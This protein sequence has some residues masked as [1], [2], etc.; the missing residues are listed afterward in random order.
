MDLGIRGRRAVVFGAG[1]GL[2]RAC[3]YANNA[4]GPPAGEFREF[5]REDRIKV[6]GQ[7]VLLDGGLYPGTF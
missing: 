7:N 4:G 1:K 6:A 5:R 3:A 2:G